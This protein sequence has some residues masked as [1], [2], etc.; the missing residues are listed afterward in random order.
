M[1]QFA[2]V[3]AVL[4]AAV[5][6]GILVFVPSHTR[7]ERKLDIAASTE[8]VYSL[9]SSNSGFQ[10]FNPYCDTDPDLKIELFGP[11]EGVGSAFRFSGKEGSGTQTIT[12]IEPNR[13]VKMHIDL[14]FMGQPEQHFLLKPT[15]AGTEV[16]WRVDMEFGFNVMGRIFGLF[17]EGILGDTYQRGL[18]NLDRAVARS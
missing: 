14:G 7:V 3:A 1:S 4:V 11:E 15:S 10:R 18:S 9:L 12:A 8:T 13:S 5:V 2:G 17:A 6:L 16:T